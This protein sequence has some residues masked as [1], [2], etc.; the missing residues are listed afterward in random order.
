MAQDLI[1]NMKI[2]TGQMKGLLSDMKGIVYTNYS[3]LESIA[4]DYSMAVSVNED[5]S[6]EIDVT[7]MLAMQKVAEIHIQ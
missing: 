3:L 7:D 2:D 1:D 5:G 6:L 4:E